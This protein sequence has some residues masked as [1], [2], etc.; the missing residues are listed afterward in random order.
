M[1]T[2][3]KEHYQK[4][5]PRYRKYR[6]DNSD[7]YNYAWNKSHDEAL[8]ILRANTDKDPTKCYNCDQVRKVRCH[9]VDGDGFNNDP[10]NLEWCCYPC[11]SKQNSRRYVDKK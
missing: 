9:H 5:A 7:R 10:N 1:P 6:N 8:E 11:D 3:H 2:D 4:Y